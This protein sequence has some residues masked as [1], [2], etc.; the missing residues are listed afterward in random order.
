MLRDLADLQI[1]DV[2]NLQAPRNTPLDLVINGQSKY[3]GQI[4][5]AGRRAAFRV[6]EP[7]TDPAHSLRRVW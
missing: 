4:M 1:G 2:L 5:S 6:G 7:I 3:R